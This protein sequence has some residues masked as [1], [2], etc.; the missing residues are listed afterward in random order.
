MSHIN[1]DQLNVDVR[2]DVEKELKS[3]GLLEKAQEIYFELGDSA[4]VSYIRSSY[5][6]LSKVYHPD[7]N[8]RNAEKAKSMQQRLNRLS[9]LM[10]QV[11]DRALTQVI[12][13]S[14]PESRSGKTKILVVE[15]EVHLQTLF[16]DILHMEG[17]R[18][19]VASDGMRGV[20]SFLT[21]K[22]DLVFTDL[23]LPELNGL[24]MVRRIRAIEPK[25]KVIMV[26][27]FFGIGS[28]RSELGEEVNKYGY[29]TLAKPFKTSVMLDVVRDYLAG[30]ARV[31]VFV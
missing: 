30:T 11:D 1:E 17:Y 10:G 29:P 26:S 8:P 25:I 7:L 15:D 14:A 3:L 23:V 19:R 31:N 9:L 24:E 28:L 27:G 21:F 13:E 4:A 6:L 12:A 2:A 18:V 5:R 16:R 20:R 22:P